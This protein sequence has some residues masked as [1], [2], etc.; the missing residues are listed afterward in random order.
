MAVQ[1]LVLWG[2][3]N[4]AQFAGPS[5]S[6]TAQEA[7]LSALAILQSHGINHIDTAQRYGNGT[8][9][10]ILGHALLQSDSATKFTIDTKW[11]VTSDTGLNPVDLTSS[12]HASLTKL[13]IPLADTFYLHSFPHTSTDLLACLRAIDTLHQSRL[14]NHFGLS[15]CTAAQ[16][17]EIHRLC[18]A[19][20]LTPPT[21][22]QGMYNAIH[23]REVQTDLLPLLRSLGIGFRAYSPMAGGFLTKSRADLEDPAKAGRF[24]ASGLYRDTYVNEKMLRVLDVWGEVAD[25]QGRDEGREGQVSRAEIAY[26]WVVWHAGLDSGKGD[27]VIVGARD[28]KQLDETLGF[29]EKG[30]L[31]EEVVRRI[32]EIAAMV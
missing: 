28:T 8:A 9:E 13:N 17:T 26:R 6:S 16:I 18:T 27:G 23:R 32:E 31:S 11:L 20:S 21:V 30:K 7:V 1:P 19:H 4:L 5:P 12:A 10:E 22:Y 2:T 29:V 25:A 14:F 24:A 3:G 15:N